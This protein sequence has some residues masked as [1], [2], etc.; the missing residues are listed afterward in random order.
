MESAAAGKADPADPFVK[1]L[2]DFYG[3]CMDEPK[4]E[5]ASLK[6]LKSELAKHQGRQDPQA[7]G[8]P[9]RCRCTRRGA[10]PF[11]N[12]GSEQDVKDATLV[13]GGLDQGGLG[14]PDRDYYLSDDAKMK[15]IRD[16]YVA[17]VEKMLDARSASPPRRPRRTPQTVIDARDRAGQGVAATRSSAAIPYK[18]YHR[19]ERKGLVKLAPALRLERVLHALGSTRT[20]SSINVDRPGR[21]SPGWTSVLDH[22]DAEVQAYLRWH[23]APRA[24]QRAAQGLRQTSAS[25]SRAGAHRRKGASRR[26][27]SAAWR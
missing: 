5:T 13:I 20:C 4:A 3:T 9:G 18:V 8:D 7:A 6:E 24:A 14:L 16:A 11:F 10:G 21:S 1:K 22:A 12:F 25:P 19:L 26:A 27:G 23:A 2:G 17:H 15:D